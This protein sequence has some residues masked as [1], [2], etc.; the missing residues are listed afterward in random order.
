MN[1]EKNLEKRTENVP[2]KSKPALKTVCETEKLVNKERKV[3][4][5]N[6]STSPRDQCF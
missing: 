6:L 3:L 5:K 4:E 2:A 1:K